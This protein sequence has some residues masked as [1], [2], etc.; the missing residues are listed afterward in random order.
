MSKIIITI[1]FLQIFLV[2]YSKEE[3]LKNSCNYEGQDYDGEQI[4]DDEEKSGPAGPGDNNV[5]LEIRHCINGIA[6][7]T[8]CTSIMMDQLF[9]TVSSNNVMPASGKL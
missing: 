1:F 2:L 6:P 9:T 5:C 8:H 3:C 4:E 7:S